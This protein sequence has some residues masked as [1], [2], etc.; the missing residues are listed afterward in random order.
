M[1]PRTAHHP[2]RAFTLIELLVVIAIIAILIGLLLPA[3][4]KV[5]DAAART[6]CINNLKQIGVALHNY[7]DVYLQFPAGYI[8]GNK[9][10]QS[11][12]DNDIGPGW[13]WAAQLL[14][15]V[16]QGGVYNQ[17]NLNVGVGLGVNAAP[18]QIALKVYQCPADPYQQNFTVWPTNVVVAHGNYIGCSGWVECFGNAG[19]DYVPS[20]DGGAAEDGDG[21]NTPTGLA[22][23]GLFYRNSRNTFASVTDGLSNTVIVGERCAQHSPTTWTGAVTGGQ[24][25]AW[26]A[27][28]PWTPPYTPSSS[29]PSGPN[30]TAYDNADY[31]EALVLGHGNLTHLPN[32]DNPFFDPDT[33]WSMHTG[34]ANFLF[35]DGSVHFLTSGINP[36]TYQAMMTIGAGDIVGSY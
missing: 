28:T 18:C 20:S 13:G 21:A 24:C 36:A 22:G 31:G 25:P 34:G 35:G 9:N 27:T 8:D 19:G 23:D 14:P 3:V 15:F 16:E 6:Q 2:K 5:R 11:T 32:S 26:M 30:G 4:Q 10:P 33:F 17:I 7:H 12:P 1:L 29:A